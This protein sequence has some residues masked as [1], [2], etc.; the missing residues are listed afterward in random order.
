MQKEQLRLNIKTGEFYLFQ[1]THY[2]IYK[3]NHNM[4]ERIERGEQQT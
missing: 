4:T 1:C 3:R 2:Y